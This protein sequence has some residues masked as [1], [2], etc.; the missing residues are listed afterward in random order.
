MNCLN[1]SE[2]SFNLAQQKNYWG[3]AFGGSVLEVTYGDPPDSH[4]LRLGSPAI[5]TATLKLA[6]AVKE[7]K[8]DVKVC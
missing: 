5:A 8:D 4:R 2:S 1:L 6:E 3:A 7:L